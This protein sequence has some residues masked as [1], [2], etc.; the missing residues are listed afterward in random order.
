MKTVTITTWRDGDWWIAT[1]DDIEGFATQVR[2]LDQLPEAA[3]DIAEL[4]DDVDDA[5]QCTFVINVD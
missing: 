5:D 3:R 2:R 1:S 4:T